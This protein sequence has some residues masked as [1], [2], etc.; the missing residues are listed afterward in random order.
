M[1]SNVG[2]TLMNTFCRPAS[3]FF[4]NYINYMDRE[5]AVKK[6]HLPDFDLFAAENFGL[7][8][9]YMDYM[10]NPEKA[11]AQDKPE[12][13]SG[14]FTANRDNLSKEEIKSGTYFPEFANCPML[15][16]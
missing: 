11:H 3:K 6:E 14:L 10:G 7:F 8:S 16:S 1:A 5:E 12:K 4:A 13:I 15:F 2:I 9:G